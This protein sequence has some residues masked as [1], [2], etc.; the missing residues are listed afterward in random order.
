MSRIFFVDNQTAWMQQIPPTLAETQIVGSFCFALTIMLLHILCY[1]GTEQQQ[2]AYHNL[3]PSAPPRISQQEMLVS[4]SS[5]NM[6][7]CY[8]L[9]K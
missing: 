9:P 3:L 1:F 5:P 6:F 8:L 7:Q 2:Y 4:H